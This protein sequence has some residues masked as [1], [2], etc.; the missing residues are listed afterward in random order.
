MKSYNRFFEGYELRQVL[1]ANGKRK[2]EHMYIGDYYCQMLTSG[3]QKLLKAGYLFS[4]LCAV[5]I[6]IF[7]GT[8]QI[9]INRIEAVAVFQAACVFFLGYML[10]ALIRYLFSANHRT[11]YEYKTSSIRMCRAASGL[12]VSAS[13]AAFSAFIFTVIWGRGQLLINLVCVLGYVLMAGF[14]LGIRCV[15]KKIVYE[16]VKSPNLD[17]GKN[18][19]C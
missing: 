5:F 3:K 6:L 16:K 4:F 13:G 12:A 18:A 17:M 10:L 7:L 14:G 19:K 15:E 11:I 9:A 1:S 8:L 2:M